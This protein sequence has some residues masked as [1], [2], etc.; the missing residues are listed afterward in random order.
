M[1]S[2]PHGPTPTEAEGQE[3]WR[4]FARCRISLE[5]HAGL[6][7]AGT[8]VALA[9]AAEANGLVQGATSLELRDTLWPRGGELLVFRHGSRI[10]WAHPDELELETEP[11][12]DLL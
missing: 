4:R 3:S 11:A 7:P 1:P 8:R 12:L 5:T 9:T 10:A 2:D 6:L